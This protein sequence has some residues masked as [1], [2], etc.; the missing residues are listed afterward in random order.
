M[1]NSEQTYRRPG[2]FNEPLGLE[3]QKLK[4]RVGLPEAKTEIPVS[5]W[6]LDV[7]EIVDVGWRF[8]E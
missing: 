4:Y 6:T 2:C 5:Y 1:S 7:L 8:V 3:K